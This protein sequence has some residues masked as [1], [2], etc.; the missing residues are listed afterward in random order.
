MST[1]TKVV[2]AEYRCQEA[3]KVPKGIDLEDKT[4]VQEWWV[5]WNKLKILLVDG[6]VLEIQPEWDC[7]GDSMKRPSEDPTIECA[8]DYG[9]EEDEEEEDDDT[10]VTGIVCKKCDNVL[11]PHTASEHLDVTNKIHEC[12]HDG[13]DWAT[14]VGC[15][16]EGDPAHFILSCGKYTCQDCWT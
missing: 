10:V 2:I 9:F 16:C 14:C 8:E 15:E 5:K 3:F 12:P 1:Q 7:V 6:T 13:V 11:P 4:Q